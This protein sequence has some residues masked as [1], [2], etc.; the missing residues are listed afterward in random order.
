M[1]L[2]AYLSGREGR[3]R[4]PL[5]ARPGAR[6]VDANT[7][8]LSDNGKAFTDR[9]FG[10]CR[11]AATG[12]HDFHR[13]CAN[14]RIEHRLTPPMRLQTNDM[15]EPL[16]GWID[17]IL[18]NQRFRSAEDLEQ[19]IQLYVRLYNGQLTQ[20]AL[21]SRTPIDALRDWQSDKPELF[22]KPPYNNTESDI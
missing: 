4:P 19:T 18:Q 1:D 7:P 5:L 10:L 3:Q 11:C 9:L 13:L 17:D 6:R 16:N 15:V 22:K 12:N 2:H 14:L 21:T 8:V 20:S